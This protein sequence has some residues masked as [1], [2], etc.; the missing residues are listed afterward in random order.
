MTKKENKIIVDASI[1]CG[2]LGRVAD[3]AKRAEE[4]GVDS[5][6]LD[7]MDGHF[8]PNISFG[9]GV[10]AAINRN[11]ELFLDAHLMIYNP[12]EYVEKFIEAGADRITFHFEATED[13]EDLIHYI[14]TCGSQAGIAF[15][16]ET[17][18][19]MIPKYIGR[20][21]V[22]LLMS[23]HPGFGGQKF[24]PEV[25]EKIKMTRKISDELGA[26]QTIQVDGGINLETGREC[27]QAGANNLVSGSFLFGHPDMKSVIQEM[28]AL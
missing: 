26:T 12:Y 16:P 5:L 20:V 17:S 10:V 23:V 13:T 8:V 9:P 24:M 11:T 27:I 7:I 15:N 19:E 1:L 22:I 14:H 18:F 25:L 4:A 21:D 3:E 2:D 6:H 28:H